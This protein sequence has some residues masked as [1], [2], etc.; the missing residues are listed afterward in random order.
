MKRASGTGVMRKLMPRIG[1][2][3]P[4]EPTAIAVACH[5]AFWF[6]PLVATPLLIALHN[7]DDVVIPLGSLVRWAAMACLVATLLS[8]L[9]A[10][11]AGPRGRWWLNRGLLAG[12]VLMAVQGNVV[13]DLFHYGVFN[14]EA[15]NFRAYGWLFWAEWLG[16]IGLFLLTLRLL[17]SLSPLPAW[18][19]VL[20]LASAALL[21]APAAGTAS[22]DNG[23][24]R[25]TRVEPSVFEFSSTSNLIHLLPDGLQ[26]DVVRQVFESDAGLRAR[27]SGFVLYTD[28]V[29][30]YP[31]TAP[32]VYTLLT[33]KAFDF[34]RGYS[35]DR[36]A[37]DIKGHSYQNELAKAGYRVDYVPITA[38]VCIESAASCHPRPFNDMKSRGYS[39]HQG[40]DVL[41]SLRLVADLTLFRLLPM[42]LKE[43]VYNHGRWLLADTTMDGSSPWPDPV[44]REWT[45]NFK[46]VTGRPVYKWYHY[47]GTHLPAKWDADCHLLPEPSTERSAFLGQARCVLGGIADLLDRMRKTGIYDQSAILVTGDHGSNLAPD[48]AESPPLNSELDDFMLGAGRPALLVKRAGSRDP[49]QF[50]ARPTHLLD[51][52]ATAKA[53]AGIEDDTARSIFEIPDVRAKP[54]PFQ[55]Y[56]V[57]FFWTGDPVPFIEYAVGQPASEGSE[58]PVSAIQDYREPPGSFAPVNR[59]NA[60]GFVVGARL[61]KSPGNRDSSWI[62]GRQLAFVIGLDDIRADRNLAL[63]MQFPEW[64]PGQQFT[65]RINGGEPWRG[66]PVVP[67]PDWRVYSIPFGHR[68]QRSGANFVSVMFDRTYVSPKDDELRVA[69]RIASIRTSEARQHEERP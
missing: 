35:H 45:A 38:S 60:K 4:A 12:A 21:L 66:P 9:M 68:L 48:D 1:A 40:R 30:M 5:L 26:G 44:I 43:K 61:R 67:G 65:V 52:A 63:E 20:P 53:L 11:L 57:P 62:T 3:A 34:G 50:S 33:G 14:G 59:P 54:R 36:V 8:S 23:A 56:A 27:F 17:A 64:M 49:L 18:L 69:G 42:Y 7:P 37:A 13:N 16:W 29:G 47:I 22:L 24:P 51:L 55:H 2:R 32:S 41:Y 31:G 46:V 19:P 6:N 28:H 58:W 15:V 10:R 39:R 25:E